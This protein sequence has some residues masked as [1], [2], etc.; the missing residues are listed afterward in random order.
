VVKLLLDNNADVNTQGGIY[1]NALQAASASGYLD[2]VRLLLDEGADVNTQGGCYRNTLQAASV[3][4][5][6]DVVKLLLDN[7]AIEPQSE[8]DET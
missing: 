6:S 7:G 4:G 3:R 5:H 2:V 8:D 1:D